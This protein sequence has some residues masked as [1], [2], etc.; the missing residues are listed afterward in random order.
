MVS[1]GAA[2]SARTVTV[3]PMRRSAAFVACALL[4]GACSSLSLPSLDMFK[5]APK[6]INLQL[7]S[8]PPGA[9]AKI[10]LGPGCRTP[11]SVPITATTDFTVTFTL[12]GH[13]PQTVPVQVI[14]DGSEPSPRLAPNPAYAELEAAT[15]SVKRKPAKKKP[16]VAANP[17]PPTEAQTSALGF[18]SASAPPPAPR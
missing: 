7:E 11:C 17:A 9:D 1:R 16:V 6:P 2:P 5:S 13:Q 10:S 15:G 4:L 12:A 14:A 8:Q 18:P 3:V